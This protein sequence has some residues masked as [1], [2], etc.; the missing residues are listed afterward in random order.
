[1]STRWWNWKWRVPA[2]YAISAVSTLLALFVCVTLRATYGEEASLGFFLVPIIL[3]AY[4]GGLGP[5][6]AAT[7]GSGALSA[8][9]LLAPIHNFSVDSTISSTRLIGLVGTGVLISILMESLHR[10][11]RLATLATPEQ[12]LHPMR[13]KVWWS[14]GVALALLGAIGVTAYI[15]VLRLRDND[16]LVAHTHEVISS[17]RRVQLLVTDAETGQRGYVITADKMFL[18]PYNSA[19]TGLNGEL[20]TLGRLTADNPVQQACRG[21]LQH[22][23]AMRLEQLRQVL[24]L[25]ESKGITAAG[26]EILTRQGMNT[27][28]SI[29]KTVGLMEGREEQLLSQRE[30]RALRASL[31]SRS[32]IVLGSLMAFTF[33]GVALFLISQD[34]AGS[35]RA[36]AA[37]AEA[38]EHLEIRVKDRTVDLEMSNEE[39]RRSREQFS[40]T[41]ESIG[42]GV[43]TT[44][45][46][47]RITF[48]NAEAERLTGWKLNEAIQQ[49]LVNV[50]Q[51]MGEESR[52][53][54]ENPA[55]KVLERNGTV[56]LANHTLLINK[57]GHEVPI[58]DSGAPIRDAQGKVL[59]VVLVFRDCRA[60]REKETAL[61]ERVAVQAQLE[62]LAET[63]PGAICSFLQRP[64]GTTCFPYCN[65][66]INE[67]YA[68]PMEEL[69]RDAS[70]IFQLVHQEDIPAFTAAIEESKNNLTVWS[71]E[72]RVRHPQKGEI[73]V[74]GKGMPQ[75]QADGSTLWHGFLQDVT[76]RRMIEE[77]MKGGEARLSAIIHSALSGVITVD[78]QQNIIL[79]N[80]AAEQMFGYTEAEVLGRPL[81][82][83]I[84]QR[85]RAGHRNHIRKFG[86]TEIAG[87]KMGQ[88]EGI[89]GMRRTGEEFPVEASISQVEFSG[90]QIYT[91]ILR[92]V[93]EEKKAEDDLKQQASL[94]DLASVVV[95][96]LENRI[97]LWSRGAEKLYGYAKEEALGRNAHQLL[98]TEFPFPVELIEEILR[99]HGA[100]EGELHHRTRDEVSVY[101]ASQWVMYRDARGQPTRI[102]EVDADITARRKAEELQTRSQKL[103]ALGT[104]AGGI[105]HDFNNILLAI[106]GNVQLAMA[107]VPVDH[108]AQ[109][110]LTEIHKAGT[111]ASELVKRILGFSRPQE[112]KRHVVQ[113]E[114]VIEEALKLTRATLPAR[115]Q[116]RTHFALDLPPSKV[117]AGQ[118]HQVVVNLATNAAHAIGE[119]NGFIEVRLEAVNITADDAQANADLHEGRYLRLYVS[120]DGCGMDRA[121]LNRIF[122]PFFTTKR[123][124]EGTGLGL[125]VVHGIVAS[126]NG[127]ISVTS[128]PGEGTAFHI[129]FPVAS[130]ALEVKTEESSEASQHRNE[131]ILYVDDE[132]ALVFLATRLLERRGYSVIGFTDAVSA[133]KEF[134]A[135][136]EAFDVVVTDLSMPR[137]SGLELTEEIHR[138]RGDIP[139]VLTSGYMEAE[140]LAMAES[141]GIRETIAKPA[142]ADKLAAALEK[143]FSEQPAR[144]HSA[145]R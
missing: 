126:H 33:V 23:V 78:E 100:W 94:L 1:M 49:P 12:L 110:S 90:K 13:K 127:A 140:D 10:E 53:P 101:V 55:K 72:F 111:R 130:E 7:I 34:I 28:N 35:R 70:G 51:I 19:K 133:V 64:D 93:T 83:F 2:S 121:T 3:S 132:E 16:A 144:I 105:A 135:H 87:R 50:F 24:E 68:I 128:H 56:G 38:K 48:L 29:R 63:V 102:L 18:E 9:F 11:R 40:V 4:W 42:D 136:P 104:L 67:I 117:D 98:K 41:L 123:Q 54:M 66:T 6:I 60:E 76:A 73:W 109:Q 122:D 139:V 91:V 141:L 81:D 99:S 115:I 119:K 44:D 89:F 36:T 46:Q 37:L 27:G 39:L 80:P 88:R 96:D 138:V 52:Q 134:R 59:G 131:R 22:L 57:E 124:G 65:P 82:Q 26:Q 69:I 107:D 86:A 61:Q 95:R 142:T 92:D 25:R 62:R 116:F 118:I 17:L 58:A 30:Q 31:Y 32:I 5:G 14:F 75:R 114:P 137:M 113:L 20:A 106:N 77:Q 129:Y 74:E 120:D 85:Y 21:E 97:V 108:P 84:P 143:I 145:R 125:S 8:Y 45:A 47:T 103:E 15:Q 71:R 112:Q 43:I 79:F